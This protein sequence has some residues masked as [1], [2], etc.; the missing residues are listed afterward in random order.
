MTEKIRIAVVGAGHL[1]RFHARLLAANTDFQLIGV[2]DPDAEARNALAEELHVKGVDSHRVL[3]D[4]IDAAVIATPTEYH[5]QIGMELLL[6]GKHLLVEKPLAGN[7]SEADA[8]TECAAAGNC[9]LQVGHIERFN[10]ALLAVQDKIEQ[11]KFIEACRCSGYSFRSTDIG[12]VLDLM[13]HD[14]DI[15]LNLI[16]AKPIRIDAVG[17][18]V[19]GPQEDVA[20]ARIIFDDGCIANLSASRVSYEAVRQMQVW[21]PQAF[22]TIDYA[23]ATAK[24]AR[25][26]DALLRGDCDVRRLSLTEKQ[27]AKERFFEEW[28]SVEQFSPGSSNALEDEL[29]DFSEAIQH[30]RLPQVTGVAGRDA[31]AVCEQ[32]LESI[33]HHA[34]DAHPHSG[35]GPHGMQQPD[36][37]PVPP[38]GI[39]VPIPHRR[40]G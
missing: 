16:N 14:V 4:E 29:R 24:V 39:T 28:I 20:N 21:C 10:P 13:I 19:L 23:N 32:I 22:L 35:I 33:A 31:V 34:W 38:V 18:C 12:V 17:T 1:G 9:I 7:L 15:V 3:L 25:P 40:A 5:H 36:T 37:I 6:R 2:V 26:S 8:L 11:P 27:R 30:E